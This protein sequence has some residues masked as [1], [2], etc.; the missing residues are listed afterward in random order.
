MKRSKKKNVASRKLTIVKVL[1]KNG[2]ISQDDLDK[3]HTIFRSNAENPAAVEKAAVATGEVEVEH[4]P[5]AANG[6]HYLTLVKV[7]SD[8]YQP[9]I[10]D[11]EEWRRIFEEASKDPDFK[12][13]THKDVNIEVIELGKVIAVE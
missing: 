7:G 13:F 5:V 11:L 12:I 4:V 9:T 10:E 1:P 8:E 3:W 2:T 6:K